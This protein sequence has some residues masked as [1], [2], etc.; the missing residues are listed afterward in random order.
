MTAWGGV[1]G[2]GLGIS[3]LWTDFSKSVELGRIVRWMGESQAKQL[4]IDDRK[5][6]IAVDMDADFVVFDPVATYTVG[7]VS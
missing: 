5:G 1:S 7:T 6:S 3:L 4:K 2:L